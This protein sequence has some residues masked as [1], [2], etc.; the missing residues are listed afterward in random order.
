MPNAS[1]VVM[2]HN[3]KPVLEKTL[4]AMLAQ[5]FSGEFEIIVVNDGSTDGTVEML[6]KKFGK[7]KKIIAINQPRSYPCRARN[8]GIKKARN[9]FIVIMDDDCIP[10]KNWLQCLIDGFSSPKIGIVS[11]YDLYGGTSTA[12][13]KQ[14]LDRVG[15]FDE[16]YGYYREDT[17]LVFRIMEKGFK[18]RLVRA[19]FLHEH[20]MEAPK[21]IFGVIRYAVER[22]NYHKND[23]LLFKKHPKNA[24]KFLGVRLG[25]L[26]DPR[27]DFAA[28]TNTWWKGGKMELGSPR[29]IVFLKNSGLLNFFLIL[30]G[31]ISWV[32]LVKFFRIIGSLKFGKLLV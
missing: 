3:R 5:K 17:D 31:G 11:S 13:R 32:F 10:G 28:A 2:T 7:E 29:G 4:K 8:N 6:G 24:G 26:V 16:E 1:I 9:E 20:K 21:G 30:F 12:F 23:V 14:I 18:S 15:G 27:K 25:F 19:D 22:A